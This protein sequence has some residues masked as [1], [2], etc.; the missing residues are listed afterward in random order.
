M[1]FSSPWTREMPSA[2]DSTVPTSDRSAPPSSSPSM[3]ALRMLVISSGLI[4]MLASSP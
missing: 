2:I 4:C 3:R 1:Q